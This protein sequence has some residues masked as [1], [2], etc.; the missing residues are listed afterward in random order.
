M[1]ADRAYDADDLRRIIVALGAEPVIPGRRNRTVPIDHNW[2]LYR[3]RN[4]VER[5][6]SWLKQCRR[7]ATR[8]E[9]TASSNQ[10]LVMFVAVRHWR[11]NPFAANGHTL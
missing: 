9:K 11:Q 3:E 1:L 5:G 6:I 2:E 4:I 10:S 7:L 8:F